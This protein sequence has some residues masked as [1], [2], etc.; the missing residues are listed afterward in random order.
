MSLVIRVLGSGVNLFSLQW[1]TGYDKE[2]LLA[3]MLAV[4]MADRVPARWHSTDPNSLELLAGTPI[5]CLLLDAPADPPFVHQAERK[6]VTLFLVLR[7]GADLTS[8]APGSMN[9]FVLEGDFDTDAVAALRSRVK[10]PVI[11]LTSRRHIR[12]DTKES[13]TGTWEGLWPGI[14]IEHGGTRLTGPTA[15]PWI[16]TNSG[17]LSFFRAATDAAIWVGVG[18]PA[19]KVF[20][21]DRYLQAIGDAAIAGARWIVSLDQDLQQRLLAREPVAMR[22]WQ[23]IGAYLR[24]FEEHREWSGYTPYS[25]LALVEDEDN[26]GLL[27]AGLLDMISFQHTPVRVIPR[28]RLD[29]HRLEGVR[30]VLNV[31]AAPVTAEEAQTLDGFTKR[32]GTLLAPPAEWKFPQI[33]ENQI[34]PGRRQQE[35]L[36]PMWE[37]AYRATARK[38][39]GVRLFNVASTVAALRATRNASSLL[40]HLLNFTDFAGESITIHALGKWKQARLYSPE[41]PVRIL[42][43]YEIPEGTGIDVDRIPVFASI[44]LDQ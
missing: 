34:T 9:G 25:R 33:P 36:E 10:V 30:I 40:I 42:Q 20:P 13:V 28:R 23:R 44:R 16:D 4:G 31:D 35:Q 14:E 38:N 18:P 11:E 27:S 43:T 26:G 7:P 3:L 32:G 22:A 41:A 39:F 2:V 1:I 21:A 17:F 5:N 37:V 8:A 6:G 19:G 24:Y 12:L 29:A 15:T